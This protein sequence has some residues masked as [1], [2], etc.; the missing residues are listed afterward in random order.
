MT[1]SFT[2]LDSTDVKTL[3]S[4]GMIAPARVPHV[5]INPSFHHRVPSPRSGM[6]S[7]ETMNVRTT[8]MI[9]VSHT[10]DVSGASKFIFVA[11]P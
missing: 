4:S 7:R 10:S 6:S 1:T 11:D 2:W 9:E 3:T 8:E 5:M